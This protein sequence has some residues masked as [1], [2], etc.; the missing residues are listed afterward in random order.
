MANGHAGIAALEGRVPEALGLYRSAL[1]GY[2]DAGC[3]FDVALT[4]LDMAALIGP[5]E[6]GVRAV[7]PEGRE[8][9]VGLGA[10]SLVERLDTLVDEGVQPARTTRPSAEPT[11]AQRVR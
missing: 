6:P 8:I 7:I 4:V 1:A 5:E 9:L 10:P 2:R 11:S 3:R